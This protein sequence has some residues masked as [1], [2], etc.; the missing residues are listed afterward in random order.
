MVRVAVPCSILFLVLL[1]LL[2]CSERQ[3]ATVVIGVS[4]ILTGDFASAGQNMVNAATLALERTPHDGIDIRLVVEDASCTTG[5]GLSAAK[6]LVEIDG[7]VAIIGG[8]CS[9]DTLAAAPY[10]NELKIPYLTPVTGGKNIDEAGEYVLRTGNSDVQAGLRPAEDMIAVFGFKRVALVTDNAEYTLDI[11][12][13]FKQRCEE[14]G[15]ATVF[16]EMVAMDTKDFRTVIL[17]LQQTDPDAIMMSSQLGTTGGYF[18]K[19][20]R[21]AGIDAP[22]FTTFT[23]VVS[24]TAKDIAGPSMEGTYFY[25][26]SYAEDSAAWQEFEAAYRERYGV[27]PAIDFHAAATHDSMVLLIEAIEAVGPDGEKIHDWI[28]ANGEGRTGLIGTYTIDAQGNVDTGFTLK[29]VQNGTFVK[30]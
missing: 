26:P 30:V 1:L 23:T 28:L 16:D 8:T 4:T 29:R 17:K 3:D 19:Q 6:K 25:D 24:S 14:L 21:D 10:V 11:R 20:A 12:N 2:G 9:G 7:A 18:I 27:E 13:T 22:I 15:G 5:A